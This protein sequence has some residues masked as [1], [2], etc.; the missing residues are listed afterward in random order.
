MLLIIFLCGYAL[1]ATIFITATLLEGWANRGGWTV[2][3]FA[4]L[5]A[6]LLWPLM[7]LFLILHL[8]FSQAFAWVLKRFSVGI[9]A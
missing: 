8:L 3:R 6:C 2:Y 7:I 5:I 1:V 9:G 4:G